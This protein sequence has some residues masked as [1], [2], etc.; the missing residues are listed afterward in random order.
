M[1]SLPGLWF[2]YSLSSCLQKEKKPMYVL[3]LCTGCSQA[4]QVGTKGSVV[5]FMGLFSCMYSLW[6]PLCQNKIPFQTTAE[7][8][9]SPADHGK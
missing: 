9:G 4:S 5:P 3:E 6:L 1:A 2:P 7:A 8:S